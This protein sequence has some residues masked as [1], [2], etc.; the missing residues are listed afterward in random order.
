MNGAAAV[1]MAKKEA[2]RRQNIWE[3]VKDFRAL[4]GIPVESHIVP[5]VLGTEEKAV[6]ASR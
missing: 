3:R 4:T 6:Q 5:I 2:W 1:E